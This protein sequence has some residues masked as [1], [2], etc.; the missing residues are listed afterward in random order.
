MRIYKL[1]I[2]FLSLL[3]V[4][5]Y[6]KGI[7]KGIFNNIKKDLK[8]HIRL[9]GTYEDF[10][11]KDKKTGKIKKRVKNGYLKR[12]RLNIFYK[13]NKYI[14]YSMDFRNDKFNYKNRWKKGLNIGTAFFNIKK[15]FKNPLINFKIL[16]A[17]LDVSRT[18]TIKSACLVFYDRPYV[19]DASA[20]FVSYNRFAENF[21]IY[22]N[23]KYK[24][25]YQIAIGKGIS[26]KKFKD[27]KGNT[28]NKIGY[29]IDRGYVYGGKLIISPFPDW[30]ERVRTETYFGKGKHFEVGIGY[31][32]LN[33]LKFKDNAGVF[34]TNRKLINY[35]LSAH[36]KN[37]FMEAEYFKF[38]GIEKNFSDSL[39]EIG[40]SKGWYITGEFVIPELYY[41]APFVRYEN[42]IK[43]D[44]ENLKND[45]K[46]RSKVFGINWYLK[47]NNIKIG[48]VYQYDDYGR[49][50]GNRKVK[51][52]KFVSQI[53]F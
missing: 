8:F 29:L 6:A 51:R 32:K 50:I 41:F 42:W 34:S 25:F 21:Q 5:A 26:S 13:F 38:Y 40:K 53:Y 9:Q 15:P 16:R 43:W 46:L 47:G 39:R 36:Y 23:W 48:F 12:A 19:A 22:G 27:V 4:V 18:E 44:N 2:F 35:E 7:D 20:Q 3:T 14:Y 11:V 45:Y 1:V 52:F 37:F 10:K 17:K 28:L 24:F 31:W 30:E 49:Y 33:N